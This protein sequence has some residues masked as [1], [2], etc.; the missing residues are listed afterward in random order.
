MFLQMYVLG[1]L[2]SNLHLVVSMSSVIKESH[3]TCTFDLYSQHFMF[4]R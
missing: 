4:V 2:K 1:L 3:V